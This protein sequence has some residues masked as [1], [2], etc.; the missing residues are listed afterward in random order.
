M[1]LGVGSFVISG[2]SE[3]PKPTTNLTISQLSGEWTMEVVTSGFLP[4]GGRFAVSLSSPTRDTYCTSRHCA[5]V[6]YGHAD[7]N[8][9]GIL[10]SPPKSNRVEAAF[11]AADTLL[12]RVGEGTDAGEIVARGTFDGRE[13]SGRWHQEFAGE[14][15]RGTFIMRRR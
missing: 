4:H 11:L 6:V 3:S 14:G 1:W 13:L 5:P 9:N 8:W 7:G 2:C 12:I 10:R 15:P